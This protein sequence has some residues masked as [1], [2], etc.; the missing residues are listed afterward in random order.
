M[1]DDDEENPGG[2]I[3]L[4][5]DDDNDNGVPDKDESGT[6]SG[7]TYSSEEHIVEDPLY[8]HRPF[9]YICP[10]EYSGP[11]TCEFMM[12]HADLYRRIEGWFD[13]KVADGPL[14]FENLSDDHDNNE[15]YQ[16]LA[17]AYRLDNSG[18]HV[19]YCRGTV[20]SGHA[21]LQYWHFEP[22]SCLPEAYEPWHEGDW[23]M[24]QI[25][26]KL[27][28]DIGV[29][30]LR[31]IAVT[32][33]Q[34]YYGQT[35]RWDEIGNGPESQDQ[36]YV[37]KSGHRP[38]VHVALRSHATYFRAG[39]FRCPLTPGSTS[40]HGLQ[41]YDA[42]NWPPILDDQTDSVYYSYMLETFHNDM[43]SHWA[44]RW[45]QDA[46]IFESAM[47][48]RSPAYRATCVNV[49]NNPKGFNNNYVKEGHRDTIIE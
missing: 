11:V 24:F 29:Q 25:A 7:E 42:P 9:V 22:S 46:W 18:T 4:N 16:D 39:Y 2:Y 12:Q 15:H 1:A 33:S 31:P 28:Q 49:W 34:H 10:G 14:T 45:G 6:V 8:K 21:F 3:G 13:E 26:L 35:I 17:D 19:I 47:G 48:P 5:D 41:Y 23:E 30:E 27:D 36:D 20:D 32:G 40:N 43:I 37:G 38:Y 44:G